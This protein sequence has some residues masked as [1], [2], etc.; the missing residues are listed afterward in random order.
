MET[1]IYDYN[2]DVAEFSA[3]F[4]LMAGYDHDNSIVANESTINDFVYHWMHYAAK[5]KEKYGVYVSCVLHP[6]KT[7]YAIELGCPHTG[8]NTITVEGAY[9]PRFANVGSDKYREA[10]EY[11]VGKMKE[12][13]KQTTVRI[14]FRNVDSVY[15]RTEQ[16]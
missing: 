5:A 16:N 15:L 2:E 11:I 9:N 12:H 14:I 8:E 3:T 7:I 6:T 1:N 4:G 13:L 10:V